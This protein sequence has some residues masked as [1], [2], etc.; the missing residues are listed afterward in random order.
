MSREVPPETSF[1]DNRASLRMPLP[2]SRR[3]SAS[4]LSRESSGLNSRTPPQPIIT[5]NRQP[6]VN[7]MSSGLERHGS[8]MSIDRAG[9]PA[10]H[11]HHLPSDAIQVLLLESALHMADIS[12]PV[13]PWEIY[14]KWLNRVMEEFYHQGGWSSESILFLFCLYFV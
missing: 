4:M 5:R 9:T 7:S 2:A 12:N 6:S 14:Q 8:G 11:N 1:A 3:Q 10:Y 13:K